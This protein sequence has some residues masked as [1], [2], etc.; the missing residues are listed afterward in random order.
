VA[1]TLETIH[2][3]IA[4]RFYVG[5]R[6]GYRD[7]SCLQLEWE[8]LRHSHHAVYGQVV[9]GI[10]GQL[11]SPPCLGLA[12]N[13]YTMQIGAILCAV[14]LGINI[15][16]VMIE[17]SLPK[18]ARIVTGLQ[19]ARRAHRQAGSEEKSNSQYLRDDGAKPLTPFS[20]DHFKFVAISIKAIPAAF[21]R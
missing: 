10:L 16:Y 14:T 2:V 21:C 20:K 7:G 4:F 17:R 19:V 12:L 9:L 11:F 15:A 18:E 8:P 6:A 5:L 13:T 3:L 1:V